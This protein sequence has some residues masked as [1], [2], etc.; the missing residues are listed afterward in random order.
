M[1][2]IYN[3]VIKIFNKELLEKCDIEKSKRK[4]LDNLTTLFYSDQE[5]KEARAKINE[6]L[7]CTPHIIFYT[8]RLIHLKQYIK[9]SQVNGM[10]RVKEMTALAELLHSIRKIQYLPTKLK[11]RS[12]D[13]ALQGFLRNLTPRVTFEMIGKV[14]CKAQRLLEGDD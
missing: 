6:I 14:L 7:D 1:F 4:L 8:G 13:R 9:M 12:E 10:V 3:G 5:Q 11:L 2:D